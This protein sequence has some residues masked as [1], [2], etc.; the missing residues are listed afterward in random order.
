M[1]KQK[2][3]SFIPTGPDIQA[4]ERDLIQSIQSVEEIKNILA[5]TVTRLTGYAKI[6]TWEIQQGD[7]TGGFQMYRQ[8]TGQSIT[9]IFTIERIDGRLEVTKRECRLTDTVHGFSITVSPEHPAYQAAER[10]IRSAI[11]GSKATWTA[12][13]SV[14]GVIKGIQVAEKWLETEQ[15]VRH[16]FRDAGL[17]Y[18]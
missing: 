17:I 5:D 4:I 15:N 16:A 12:I 6:P 2:N 7:F 9:Q 1:D 18:L 14:D 10:A 8:A 3:P 11:R 13:D